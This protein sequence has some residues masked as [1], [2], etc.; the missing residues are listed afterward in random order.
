MKKYGMLLLALFISLQFVLP[1]ET[2]GGPAEDKKKQELLKK[3]KKLQEEKAKAKAKAAEIAAKAEPSNPEDVNSIIATYENYYNKNCKTQTSSRCSDAL[4]SLS[5]N[6]YNQAKDNFV[7]GQENYERKMDAWERSPIGAEPIPP[8]PDYTKPLE[9]YRVAVKTY[10]KSMKVAEGFFQIGS[11]H[12]LNGALEKSRA[13]F[14]ALVKAKPDDVR[15]AAAH[16]R[17]ADICFADRDYTCALTNLDAM[18]PAHINDDIKEMA[19]F[20]RGEIYY[21]RGDFDKSAEIFGTYIDKCDNRIFPKRELRGEALEYLAVSFADMPN[22]ADAAISYF[23]K[24]GRRSYEDTVIY[25]VGMKNYD[26]G[27]NDQAVTAL[28]RAIQKFPNYVD[29][30][31]AQT[32]IVYA[33]VILKKH[34][35]A[36]KARVAL[37]D[38][39]GKGSP[40][41]M[42]HSTEAVVVAKANEEVKKALGSIAIYYHAKAQSDKENVKSNYNEALKRYLQYVTQYPEDKWKAYE[43]TYNAAEAYS[44]LG[45]FANAAKFYNKVAIADLSVFP[46]FKIEIDT[47]GLD[48][49]EIEKLKTERKKSPVDISQSD[50]SFNAIVALGNLRKQK[51]KADSLSDSASYA[52]SVTKDFITYI[53]S[54]QE[55]FPKNENAAEVL[56][57]AADVQFKGKDYAAVIAECNKLVVQYS[58]VPGMFKRAAKLLGDAYS[59]NKQFDLAISQYDTLI[60]LEAANVEE[61]AK[62]I[63]LASGAIFK[64]GAMLRTQKL[65]TQAAAE[66]KKISVKYPTTKV[67]DKAWFEAATCYE[68]DSSFDSAAIAFK[69]LT[70]KFPKSTLVE[71]S[72][73]RA[74]EN[75]EKQNKWSEAAAIMELAAAQIKKADFAIPSLSKAS[76]FYTKA[77]MDEKSADMYFLAYKNYPTDTRTPTALYNAGLGYEKA[78]NFNRAIEVYK[79]LASK[80]AESEFASAGYYSIGFCYKKMEKQPE[81]AAAFVDYSQKFTE[82]RPKQI[83][84]LLL[85]TEAYQD[86]NNDAK[87]ESSVLMATKIFDK[88]Q[89][90]AAIAPV[91]GA[92]AYFILGELNR[93]KLEKIQLNGKNASAVKKQLDSKVDAL[94][95][96]LESY[97]EAMKQQVQEWTVRSTYS[98]AAVY[99][100]FAK[101]IKNQRIFGSDDQKLAAKIGIV[102]GL[103]KYY[104]KA[105]EK[106]VWVVQ[107]AQE[108][109]FTNDYVV[110]SEESLM[111][112]GFRKGRLLEEVGEIFRDAPIPKGMTEDD[113]MAYREILD[114][115]YFTALDAALPK[116]EEALKGAKSLHIGHNS[117]VDS[118]KSRIEYIDP[119]SEMMAIDLD[120]EKAKSGIVDAK[121]L[122]AAE[123]VDKDLADALA[124]IMSVYN[125]EELDAATKIARLANIESDAKRAI[126]EEEELISDYKSQLGLE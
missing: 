46:K 62:L 27:Q 82:D 6:Y 114:E 99:V 101:S 115:K 89:K 92:K 11:I 41:I 77:K 61:K 97:A 15:A 1:T 12:L 80:Y 21:N 24:K 69:Q 47:V 126:M 123:Q 79:I 118:I 23:D 56:Y 78:K 110:K 31:V 34:D 125:S 35:E 3:I 74:S 122:T 59:Q 19:H 10:P 33:Y 95:P 104:D 93:K 63:D 73:V 72:F 53:H 55:K 100:D 87:A 88:Y 71:K 60:I 16:F 8:I 26:H 51:I 39:Y 116:Y 94:K 30:P 103:D 76:Q 28:S 54:F 109:G 14:E 119:M 98:V 32:N 85:A 86:M 83:N 49:Q 121:A 84:A 120:A 25:R 22:G 20:R 5:K 17:I 2:F 50:A 70:Q 48:Q 96:V 106:L 67:V 65:Y 45:D 112:M 4:Y 75:Y 113:Q 40:W 37:V 7:F 52:L 108:Q 102:A 38:T 105:I 124:E 91:V 9:S 107:I 43:Y 68:S 58:V 36:N 90:K 13:A 18:N 29:A 81:M 44:S 111:E 42:S 57:M 64:K 66:F 117:W